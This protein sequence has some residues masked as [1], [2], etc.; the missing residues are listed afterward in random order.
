MGRTAVVAQDLGGF[1][2]DGRVKFDK[3]VK[4]DSTDKFG[5]TG[6]TTEVMI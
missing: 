2:M 1:V 3:A 5:G 6:R 4:Y